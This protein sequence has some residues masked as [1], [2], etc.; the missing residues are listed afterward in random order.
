LFVQCVCFVHIFSTGHILHVL[1]LQPRIPRARS[2][3]SVNCS[4]TSAFW[5]K[6]FCRPDTF[7]IFSVLCSSFRNCTGC[8]YFPPLKTMSSCDSVNLA[9]M[10]W[11]R[12]TSQPLSLVRLWNSDGSTMAWLSHMYVPLFPV[13]GQYDKK[14]V[15]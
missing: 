8:Q 5:I 13:L 3:S 7:A 12:L 11:N 2:N 14:S 9:S 6:F 10:I 1:A 4:C 15:E